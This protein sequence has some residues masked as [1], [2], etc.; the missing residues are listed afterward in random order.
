MAFSHS[1]RVRYAD[2][3]PQGV[4]FN[5]NYLTYMDQSMTELWREALGGY[6]SMIDRGLDMVVVEATLRYH[7]P[8]RFD[9]LL[10]LE[11]EVARLGNTSISTAHRIMRDDELLLEGSLH[12]VVVE[13]A[14]QSKAPLPD[15]LRSA[16]E[17]WTR[18]E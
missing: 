12:H 1:L 6:R 8:G 15:W 11:V 7:Q 13:L 5:A 2:C 4:V 14:T 18:A 16:L 10:R 3:D 9:D 17:P